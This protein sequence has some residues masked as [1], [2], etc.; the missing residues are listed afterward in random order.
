[1]RVSFKSIIDYTL[2]S[3]HPDF[4]NLSSQL[5]RTGRHHAPT[6][7]DARAAVASGSPEVVDALVGA[8]SLSQEERTNLATKALQ[9]WADNPLASRQAPAIVQA[10]LKHGADP[11]Q[12]NGQGHSALD[13]TMPM[14]SRLW[15]EEANRTGHRK[16]TTLPPAASGTLLAQCVSNLRVAAGLGGPA[17]LDSWRQGRDLGRGSGLPHPGRGPSTLGQ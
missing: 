6:H 14:V 16:G 9:A 1:M 7:E 10:L 8:A 5:A 15:A 2:Q 13:K 12:K 3:K 17:N 4:R 11:T